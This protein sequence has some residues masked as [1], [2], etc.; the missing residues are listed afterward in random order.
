[1]IGIYNRERSWEKARGWDLDNGA[2]VLVSYSP[3][4][5]DM[6]SCIEFGG[7][8]WHCSDGLD[9]VPDFAKDWIEVVVE[10]AGTKL[11]R[12]RFDQRWR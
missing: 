2:F 1:M 7:E 6:V 9:T 11:V 12:P 8:V 5:G 4:Y 10:S 3:V